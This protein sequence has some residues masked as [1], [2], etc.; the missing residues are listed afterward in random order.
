MDTITLGQIATVLAWMAG[1]VGSIGVLYGVIN[2]VVDKKID[3]KVDD[4]I[5]VN[6]RG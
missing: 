2:K 6:I 3:E 5:F 1:L 4:K